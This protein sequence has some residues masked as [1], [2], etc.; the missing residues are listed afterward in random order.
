MPILSA[1]SWTRNIVRRTTQALAS[2][3]CLH[4]AA[5][6]LAGVLLQGVPVLAESAPA[7]DG[8]SAAVRKP[9]P[10]IQDGRLEISTAAGNGVVPIDVSRDWSTPR[11]DVTRA[12]IVIHGWSRRDLNSGERAAAHAGVAAQDAIVITPQFLIAADIAAHALPANT[13]HWSADGWK[14]GYDAQGPASISSF[15]VV[16]TIFA[17]LADKTLFPSLKLVVLAGHSAGGQFVQRYA[18]VGH[19]QAPLAARGIGI[20]YVVANPSSYLYFDAKRPVATRAASC[21]KAEQWEYGLNGDLPP[22]VE[23][24]VS[25]GKIEQH[26]LA[27]NIVYLLGLEDT[28]PNQPELD[29][30]CAGEAEGPTRLSRGLNFVAYL[31]SQDETNF[32]QRVLEVPGVGHSSSRMF[33]SACGMAA[34]FDRQGCDSTQPPQATPSTDSPQAAQSTGVAQPSPAVQTGP[35]ESAAPQ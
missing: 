8:A 17:R 22:Y 21:A 11:P 27:Q 16:D 30:S 23:Q 20:H 1:L 35:N 26:Y 25:P 9:V 34:L 31:R 15:S 3:V 5:V 18:A 14:T 24:P 29:R 2:T 33:A 6:F 10:V 4:Y 13:L 7:A 28:D 12:V 32:T 19:G